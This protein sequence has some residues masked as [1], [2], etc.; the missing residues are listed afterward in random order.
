MISDYEK[1]NVLYIEDDDLT[2]NNII[3]FL[4]TD[5]NTNFLVT[6]RGSLKDG[7][8]FLTPKCPDCSQCDTDIILLDLILPNS[9]GINTYKT[10]RQ[11]CEYIPVVIISDH[12]DMAIECVKLGA[13]DYLLK[14]DINAGLIVRSLKYAIERKRLEEEKLKVETQFKDVI[15]STPLGVHMY[16]LVDGELIFTGHNPGA[17]TILKIDNSQFIGMKIEDAFPT[18][19][20]NVAIQYRKVIETGEAW[21]EDVV[22]YKGDLFEGSYRVHAFK[23]GPNSMA[24]TFEDVSE[25]IKILECL[26]ESEKRYRE[27]VEAT[28]AGI[29]EIDFINDKFIYVNDVMCKLTGWT[30]E[31]LLSMGPSNML[32]QK[33]IEDWIIRWDA[34][35]KG[36]YIEKTFEYEAKIKDGST[37]WT[38]VTAEYKENEEGMVVGARVI[39]IDITE[40]KR[41]REEVKKKEEYIFN[42]LEN[43]IHQWK[44][45]ITASSMIQENTIKDVNLNIASITNKVEVF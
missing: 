18:L 21:N 33:S 5:N 41:S 11:K 16:E 12:E 42:E 6:H 3:N 30:R 25:K 23:T 32:T 29:Y 9:H 44:N 17:D 15:K 4:K 40:A 27:I 26:K 34:L 36:D 31:E 8:E 20:P 14:P 10:V 7:L 45:E 13:Q 37:V 2:A 43:R 19:D 24:S 38:L 39:A 28:N 35:N 22:N 1:I